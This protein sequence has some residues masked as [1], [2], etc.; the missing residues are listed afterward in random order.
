MFKM[1]TKFIALAFMLAIVSS[2]Y[3]IAATDYARIKKDVS[4]MSQIVKGAFEADKGCKRCSVKVEGKYLAGQ[5]ILFLV[6]SNSSSYSWAYSDHSDSSDHNFSYVFDTDEFEGFADFEYVGD[7][8]NEVLPAIPAIT[9]QV[10][11]I[12]DDSTRNVLREIRREHR[13]LRQ[14]IRENEI[15]LIHLEDNEVQELEASIKEMEK[16]VAKL[17]KK[18]LEIEEKAAATH[19]EFIKER[20]EQRMRRQAQNK[21]QQMQIQNTV[22]QAFCDYGSTLRSLPDKER[23]TI[24][25]ENANRETKQDSV[26]V[27]DQPEI[28]DCNRDKATLR[29]Q[30]LSYLF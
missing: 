20:E 1:K 25:F 2:W 28:T 24:I 17:E 4:V 5:G 21:Q 27:F 22:L 18:R 23:I 9:T 14:E 15:E 13:D 10:V 3:A 30:A 16:A 11:R 19:E 7:I 6:D 29:S 12:V 8:L 26:L